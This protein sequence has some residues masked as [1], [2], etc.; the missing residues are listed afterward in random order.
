MEFVWLFNQKVEMFGV[1]LRNFSACSELSEHGDVDGS[2]ASKS[3][4]R[5]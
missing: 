3:I 4:V 1:S 2:A 5:D